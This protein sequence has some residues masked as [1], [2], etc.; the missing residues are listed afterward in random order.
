METEQKRLLRALHDSILPRPLKQSPADSFRH[1][2][3]AF[4][5]TELPRAVDSVAA[6]KGLETIIR[7]SGGSDVSANE[8]R[9]RRFNSLREE[10][11]NCQTLK[12]LPDHFVFLHQLAASNLNQS[13]DGLLQ[14]FSENRRLESSSPESGF[15]TTPADGPPGGTFLGGRKFV[16]FP[17]SDVLLMP[18]PPNFKQN[19][20]LPRIT[21]HELI[22]DL[23][24]V[25]QGFDGELVKLTSDGC[26]FAAGKEVEGVMGKLALQIGYC[27]WLCQRLKKFCMLKERDPASGI[28]SQK[29]CNVVHEELQMYRKSVV[30]IDTQ[31]RSEQSNFDGKKLNFLPYVKAPWPTKVMGMICVVTSIKKDARKLRS[32]VCEKS[33]LI[34]SCNK[35]F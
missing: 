27:G 8:A 31:V 32:T 11:Q 7:R 12:R 35:F 4:T 33:A 20:T 23:F 15:A 3:E 10:L 21:E 1:C 16:P 26:R 2:M 6:S 29:L 19:P 14:N 13:G 9:I 17:E 25:I 28:C 18:L 5:S 34:L 30:G 22:R 24:C